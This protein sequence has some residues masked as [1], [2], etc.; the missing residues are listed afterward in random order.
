MF[1]LVFTEHSSQ[2]FKTLPRERQLAIIQA[3]GK[4][5]PSVLEEAKEPLGRFNHKN[6]TF[7]RF[8]FEDLRFYFTLNEEYISCEYI[9]TKNSWADFRMRNNLEKLED[10]QIEQKSSFW[11]FLQSK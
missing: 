2:T 6:I 4:L 11:D 7:Y 9:L 3:F 8:R 1:Q 5:S 10:K